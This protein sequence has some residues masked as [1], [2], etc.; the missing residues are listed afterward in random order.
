MGSSQG[1]ASNEPSVSPRIDSRDRIPEEGVSRRAIWARSPSRSPTLGKPTLGNPGASAEAWVGLACESR[2]IGLVDRGSSS[3]SGRAC[4]ERIVDKTSSLAEEAEA[5]G[6]SKAALS[7]R[8]SRSCSARW[9]VSADCDFSVGDSSGPDSSRPDSGA[10][11]ARWKPGVCSAVGRSSSVG[12]DSGNS[13]WAKAVGSTFSTWIACR[14]G[15]AFV[16]RGLCM[17][18][19]CSGVNCGW[20]GSSRASC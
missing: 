12:L 10:I 5:K 6:D 14:G 17:A 11:V 9:N 1:F 8:S 20:V 19:A 7:S 3:R 15:S 4:C 2:R 13:T 18:C 16:G